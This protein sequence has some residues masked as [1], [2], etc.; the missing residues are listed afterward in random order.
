VGETFHLDLDGTVMAGRYIE[1]DPPHRM[2]IRWDRQGTDIPMSIPTFI[3]ITL[4]P[5]GDGSNVRVQLSGLSAE[6]AAFYS[7]L[8]VRHLDRIAAVFAG[9]DPMHGS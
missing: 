5:E 3:E 8:W 2:L 7:Q 9:N 1:V 6:E 4:T